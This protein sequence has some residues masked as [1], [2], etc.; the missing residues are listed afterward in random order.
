MNTP[1]QRIIFQQLLLNCI[2]DLEQAFHASATNY[3]ASSFDCLVRAIRALLSKLIT[4]HRC[5]PNA[6]HLRLHLPTCNT[7]EH[8]QFVDEAIYSAHNQLEL[9][10]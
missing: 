1:A 4:F 3:S 9:H 5:R 8:K 6:P 2:R 10:I 7:E